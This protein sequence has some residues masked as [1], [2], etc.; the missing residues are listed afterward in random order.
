MLRPVFTDQAEGA[1]MHVRV[2]VDKYRPGREPVGPP[3]EV[4][5]RTYWVD[6]TT[7]REI[8]DPERIARLEAKLRGG[9]Q[10][11][12]DKRLP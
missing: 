10:R 8:T 5:E 6:A 12:P 9:D 3:D 4:L 2:R 11:A 7:G 1:A